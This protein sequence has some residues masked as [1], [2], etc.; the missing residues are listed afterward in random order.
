MKA[1]LKVNFGPSTF[2]IDRFFISIFFK[3]EF[4]SKSLFFYFLVP[5]SWFD[6]REMEREKERVA[7]FR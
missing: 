4:W 2:S 7:R 6:I 5:G 3:I 1:R